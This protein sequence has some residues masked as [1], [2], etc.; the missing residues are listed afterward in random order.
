MHTRKNVCGSRDITMKTSDLPSVN[1]I[2]CFPKAT[3]V[4]D[5]LYLLTEIFHMYTQTNTHCTYMFFL[6]KNIR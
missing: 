6:N 5:L 3:T 2:T 4:N 1:T